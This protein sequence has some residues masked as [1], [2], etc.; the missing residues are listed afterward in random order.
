MG[1]MASEDYIVKP[2]DI[3][4]LKYRVNKILGN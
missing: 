3:D 1:N 2:F 4:D